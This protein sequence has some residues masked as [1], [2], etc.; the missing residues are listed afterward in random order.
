MKRIGFA[1]NVLGAFFILA[2]ALA[3]FGGL[4][5][6]GGIGAAQL[7]GIEIGV[8][9]MLIGTGFVLI[10]RNREFKIEIS[11][12]TVL[13]QIPNPSSIIW[14]A[15]TFLLIYL[16]FF[17]YPVFFSEIKIQ[18]FV[19]YIPDAWAPRIGFDIETTIEHI[20]KWLVDD[21]SPYADGTVPYTPFSLAIFAPLL[22]LG[23]PAYYIFL[24]IVTISCYAIATLLIP[25]LVGLNKSHIMLFSITGLLSYGFQFEMERGQFNMIAIALCL[26]AIYIYH[27][28]GEFRFFSYLLFSVSIQLK[29]YPLIFMIMFV[30]DWRDWKNNLKRIVGLGML[31][32]ALL[33]VL[34]YERF[35][36]FIENITIRQ[37]HFESSRIEDLS[38][39]GFVYY[40]TTAGFGSIPARLLKQNGGGIEVFFL[41]LFGVCLVSVIIHINV[42]NRSGMNLY[43]LAVCTIGALIIPTASFD[44]KLPILIAPMALIFGELP[45]VQNS[46]KRIIAVGLTMASCTAYWTTL[47]PY[48]VKPDI[49]SRNFPA[50]FIILISMT[51]LYFLMDGCL[52]AG[53]GA[54]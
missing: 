49:L 19:K 5:Q 36:E 47:Y 14:P 38:I 1:L 11:I 29:L 18:Y 32:L 26:L 20:Q 43:L 2:F 6:R 25:A 31:N 9:L 48:N 21:Q 44:Y 33:F 10:S 17:V 23:Y 7:L 54:I 30:K 50:L 28:H 40:L 34:G 51:F 35:T 15:S 27:Y 45:A 24:T 16:L 37:L 8:V 3:D 46:L 52:E 41:I 13:K 42:H 22:I 12:G 4:G 53:Q 39:R